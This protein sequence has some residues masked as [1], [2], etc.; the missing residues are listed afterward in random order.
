MDSSVP[1]GIVETYVDPDYS[2]LQKSIL[3][4]PQ[5]PVDIPP[6]INVNTYKEQNAP[7]NTVMEIWCE[8]GYSNQEPLGA[9]TGNLN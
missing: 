4:N 1:C 3:A 9:M 2:M 7:H 6:L 5:A 8:L